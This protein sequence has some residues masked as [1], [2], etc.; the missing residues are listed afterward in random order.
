[1]INVQTF[2]NK[3]PTPIISCTKLVEIAKNNYRENIAAYR[4]WTSLACD[5]RCA[6][7]LCRHHGIWDILSTGSTIEKFSG[8]FCLCF[9]AM[10]KKC[11]EIYSAHA[12]LHLFLKY[13]S[14][15]N[16][17]QSKG[18]TQSHICQISKQVLQGHWTHI[19]FST[20]FHVLW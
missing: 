5:S 17:L 18:Q 4:M 7:M 13:F 9:C 16:S 20:E 19:F 11:Y 1:M 14:M 10:C 2:K 12:S 15:F 6:C 3:W 8:Q